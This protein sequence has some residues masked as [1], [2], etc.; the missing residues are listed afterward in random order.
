M[1]KPT[2]IFDSF[3][4]LAYLQAEPG[5][6]EVK[7]LLEKAE[8]GEIPILMSAIN[9]GEVVYI[10]ERKLGR[11]T[12]ES[13]LHDIFRL[14]VKIAES[15]MSRIL[16]AANI[17][18]QYAIAYAD[19]FVVSLSKEKKGIIVTADPELKQVESLVD[20]LWL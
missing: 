9:L 14:P 19:A 13:I 1:K 2:Y 18:A 17:K 3:A 20:I 16:A 15:T 7:N 10:I 4:I 12:A 11:D 8:T 5:G 6:Q